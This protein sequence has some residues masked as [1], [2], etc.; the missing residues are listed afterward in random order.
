MKKTEE[1]VAEFIDKFAINN[2]DIKGTKHNAVNWL[3]ATLTARETE[4][5]SD[6]EK[7]RGTRGMI[8][9]NDVVVRAE[10]LALL[11]DSN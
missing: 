4:L 6:I 1:I 5:R 10:V 8:F 2:V 3:R 9:V 11:K 7:L